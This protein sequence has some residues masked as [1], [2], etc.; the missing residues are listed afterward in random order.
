[1]AI[2]LALGM[3]LVAILLLSSERIPVEVSSLAIVVLLVVS[4]LVSAREA[5]AGFSSETAIFIFALLA[6][7]QGLGATGV[8]Q[9]LGRRLVFFARFGPWALTAVL[10]VAVCA[11]SSVA[12][13]T[14]VTAA[15][16]PIVTSSA[17]KAHVPSSRLLMPMAFASM[18]GGTLF[19]F[20]TS[21]NLVT[22]AAMEDLGLGRIGFAELTPVGLPLA[23]V[24]LLV[25][26]L[27]TR[28]LLPARRD[29]EDESPLVQRQYFTEAVLTPRSRFVDRPLGGLASGLRASIRGLVRE[30]TVLPPEPGTVLRPEDHLILAGSLQD[31]LRVKD[32]R[33]IGLRAERLGTSGKGAA[34]T[35]AEVAVPPASS[36]VQQSLSACRF[37]E[38]YGLV[39]LA[40][41]R[42]PALQRLHHQLDL[43][44]SLE[45]GDCLKNIPLAAGDVL[46][47]SGPEA[48]VRALARDEALTVLGGVGYQRP[49]Y[50]RAPLAIAIFAGTVLAAGL[51]LT[52]PA[53]A[54]LAGMLL[55]VATGCLDSRTAFRVDWRVVILIG[56]LLALGRAMENS[57][58]GEFLARRILP[59]AGVIGPVGV[60]GVLM[61]TTLLLSIPMSNQAAA[62]VML[63]VAVH[64]ALELGLEPRTFAMGIC[65]SASC[66]FLTPLEPSAALVYGPGRYRFRDFLRVGAPLTGVML[67]LLTVLVPVVWPFTRG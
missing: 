43:S 51:R 7:T 30:G 41:H 15:F 10:L 4:G 39:V 17:V 64:A 9:L 42:H 49:R 32:L 44:C 36:L 54:G 65:L 52:S 60:L 5:L 27:L 16:L 59:L 33:S 25:T 62:L 20:G 53:I 46:L 2:F 47:L 55:M 58:A 56:A 24:G 21:T 37:A 50:E 3:V 26:A 67:L 22:S 11:F 45:G 31:I 40:L 63:P 1:M 12:S 66:A 48:R 57:G 8:M 13:N 14:A 23:V 18:L 35:L 29:A 28:K 19:L 61:L 34:M 6:L 38:R